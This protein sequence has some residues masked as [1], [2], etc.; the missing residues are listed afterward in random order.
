MY[1]LFINASRGWMEIKTK[2][3]KVPTGLSFQNDSNSNLKAFENLQVKN[4]FSFSSIGFLFKKICIFKII[5]WYFVV[6][7]IWS[8]QLIMIYATRHLEQ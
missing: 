2:M 3:K 6:P 7:T 1:Y 5:I 8:H 4:C